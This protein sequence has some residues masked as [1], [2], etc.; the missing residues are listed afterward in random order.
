M[1]SRHVCKSKWLYR[2]K[3]QRY[4][5]RLLIIS[6]MFIFMAWH[7]TNDKSY[8]ALFK[9]AH[10]TTHAQ[11]EYN[12]STK[13]YYNPAQSLPRKKDC[14][15]YGRE[16][17]LDLCVSCQVKL[18]HS[19]HMRRLVLRWKS[20]VCLVE[21]DTWHGGGW[22]KNDSGLGVFLRLGRLNKRSELHTNAKHLNVNKWCS[23]LPSCLII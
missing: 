1:W 20:L 18:L 13:V 14:P 22:D 9:H 7:I 2:G 19:W 16:S 23:I 12:D 6:I 10:H 15:H 11:L 21:N 3:N 8:H 4:V 5:I 17:L